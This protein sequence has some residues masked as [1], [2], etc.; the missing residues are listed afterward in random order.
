MG[1]NSGFKG[2]NFSYG[3]YQCTILHSL[4]TQS[5]W[6]ANWCVLAQIDICHS[7][8]Q[9]PTLCT[10]L[11]NATYYSNTITLHETVLMQAD[12]LFTYRWCMGSPFYFRPCRQIFCYHQELILLQRRLTDIKYNPV[13][14]RRWYQRQSYLFTANLP[15]FRR[16]YT[17]KP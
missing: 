12:R 17:V 6:L 10:V 15:H 9:A 16:W 8:T 3:S 13:R 4:N 1:F 11:F 2:L 14:T 5:L 7:F